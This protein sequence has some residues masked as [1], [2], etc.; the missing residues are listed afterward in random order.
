MKINV[1]FSVY[2]ILIAL[3]ASC[4]SCEQESTQDIEIIDLQSKQSTWQKMVA[5]ASALFA[6]KKQAEKVA[7]VSE[8]SPRVEAKK[9]VPRFSRDEALE[10]I[11]KVTSKL[12]D[13][14]DINHITLHL[15][16]M[17]SFIKFLDDIEDKKL[18][19]AIHFLI[20]NH[21]KSSA[22]HTLFWINASVK[23]EFDKVI[24]MYEE[25]VALP[26]EK[27]LLILRKKMTT[28]N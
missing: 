18:I 5:R 3:S 11:K 28:G 6:S 20:D 9:V 2:A 13:P 21:H 16:Q 25:I 19:A 12:F 26:K 4:V 23:Y 27:K 1:K 10:G 7:E 8:S 14:N 22:M 17:K 24:P 15:S